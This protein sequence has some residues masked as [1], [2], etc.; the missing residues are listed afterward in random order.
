M[1]DDRTDL[2]AQ[3]SRR[4]LARTAAKWE[5]I[6]AAS[7]KGA[8]AALLANYLTP[9]HRDDPA[10]GC[11]FASLGSDAARGGKA[12]RGAFA[13]GL[14][15]FLYILAEAV[16]GGSKAAPPAQS[17]LIRLERTLAP[18]AMKLKKRYSMRLA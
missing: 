14:R 11:A 6:A 5:R 7:P 3:A 12:V 13:D 4:A 16:P 2:A 17:R 1:N 18:L 15:P 8:Y 9:T 10:Q